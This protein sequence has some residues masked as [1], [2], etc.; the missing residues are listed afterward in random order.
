[1]AELSEKQLRLA[2]M[3][4]QGMKNKDIATALYPNATEHAGA[5][6]VSRELKKPHVAQYVDKGREHA[7]KK[8]KVNWDRIIFKLDKMLDA[9]KTNYRTGEIEPDYAAWGVAIS[10]LM[11]M[12]GQVKET[13]TQENYTMIKKGM[14]EVELQRLVFK[15][16]NED[17]VVR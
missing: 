2:E 13:P 4:S 8:Y 1:M 12:L 3:K 16:N 10:K 15:K 14:D 7:L 17:E 11:P 5:V 6:I 9:E